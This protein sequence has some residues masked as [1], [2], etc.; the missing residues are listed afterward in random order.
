MITG[1]AFRQDWERVYNISWRDVTLFVVR[2]RFRARR[3][4]GLAELSV[5]VGS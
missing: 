2:L 1:L 3:L 5:L 4:A